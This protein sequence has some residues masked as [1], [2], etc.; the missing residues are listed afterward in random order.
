MGV[1]DG[2]SRDPRWDD[3]SHI[4][5][6]SELV[7]S[8]A[9]AHQPAPSQ[10]A[11][12]PA[13]ALRPLRRELAAMEHA[14]SNLYSA[15]LPASGPRLSNVQADA[16]RTQLTILRDSASAL[17]LQLSRLSSGSTADDPS[18]ATATRRSHPLT[19]SY[20]P[21]Y[22]PQ[23]VA[24]ELCCGGGGAAIGLQRAGFDVVLGVDTDPV[25]RATYE[26]IHLAARCKDI[27]IRD[28]RHLLEAVRAALP[29]GVARPHLVWASP[30]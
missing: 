14:V 3:V 20:S 18:A 6:R 12:P 2:L 16:A 15:I 26:R 13:S 30:P 5:S 11:A 9:S 25:A 24:V 23:L 19:R 27:N 1:A 4:S 10:T 28:R 22:R 21:S 17:R 7:S 8:V 29:A